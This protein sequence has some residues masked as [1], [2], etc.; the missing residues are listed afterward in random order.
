MKAN[1]AGAKADLLANRLQSVERT[2][3]DSGGGN[4][5]G[6]EVN[7]VDIKTLKPPMFKGTSSENF[8]AWAKKAK[9]Y[10]DSNEDGI[11]RALEKIEFEK[12]V[13]DEFALEGLELAAADNIDKKL[14]QFW[15]AYTDLAAMTFVENAHGSGFKAWRRLTAEY[16]P[17]S[18]QAQ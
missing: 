14:N 13:I 2:V 5:G 10:L 4:G 18:A 15:L 16:D 8:P 11:R 9:N 7:V 12:E 3:S 17:M 6:K 1:D